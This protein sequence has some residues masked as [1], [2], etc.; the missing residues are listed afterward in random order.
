MV[1]N[2]RANC[3]S[4]VTDAHEPKQEDLGPHSAFGLH[5]KDEATRPDQAKNRPAV[6]LLKIS[7]KKGQRE[8]T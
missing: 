3:I 6:V 4:V 2:G 8:S 1:A 5:D 7:N